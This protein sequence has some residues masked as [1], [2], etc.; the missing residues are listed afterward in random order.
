MDVIQGSNHLERMLMNRLTERYCCAFL[1]E[2]IELESIFI[3]ILKH[4]WGGNHYNFS[5]EE[6]EPNWACSLVDTDMSL[7]W[8]FRYE[9]TPQPSET[10]FILTAE[11]P[12]LHLSTKVNEVI[13]LTVL[14]SN[15]RQLQIRGYHLYCVVFQAIPKSSYDYDEETPIGPYFNSG[16][17]ECDEEC[18]VSLSDETRF[19]IEI[20]DGSEIDFHLGEKKT[21]LFPSVG[22]VCENCG[23]SI[24]RSV[25]QVLSFSE[26]D[27]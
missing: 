23:K 5:M 16:V 22:M 1:H 18:T 9:E 17:I 7:Q 14:P 3:L 15:H 27:P 25:F 12:N 19:R 24:S 4:S 10:A 26:P 2:R 13:L 6:I 11:S 20:M 21:D 8:D